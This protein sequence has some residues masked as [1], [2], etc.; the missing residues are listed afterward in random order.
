[1]GNIFP[2]ELGLYSYT[3]N[4][5]GDTVD[6]QA[7]HVRTQNGPAGAVPPSDGDEFTLEVRKLFSSDVS[8]RFTTSAGRSVA[9]GGD[10]DRIRVV[11]N[12]YIVASRYEA[13][14]SGHRIKF[15]HLPDDCSIH[16]YTVAGDEVK[17][18]RHRSSDGYIFCDLRSEDGL[19]V[20]DGLYVYVVETPDGRNQVGRFA[21]IR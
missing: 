8:Y 6:V 10:L 16:I 20:A 12:P 17:R 19:D 14:S 9:G 2:D 11:P 7:V 21:V 1:M 15:N 5:D 18:L 4:G 13:S 3:V